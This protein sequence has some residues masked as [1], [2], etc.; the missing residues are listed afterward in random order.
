TTLAFALYKQNKTA[1]AL[2]LMRT[3]HPSALS[4]PERQ[5]FRAL[6]MATTGDAAG[7][8]DLLSGLRPI[9]FLPEE[10]ELVLHAGNEVARLDREKGEELKLLALSTSGEI[11]HHKGWLQALPENVR[12]GAS[13]E[14][15]TADSLFAIR[16]LTG[17]AA[18]LRKGG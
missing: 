10:C 2:A 13:V 6:F 12:S 1:E 11:D 14:M 5:M 4:T 9:G 16:D 7:A 8:A 17:L 3:L 15:Q 18:Q